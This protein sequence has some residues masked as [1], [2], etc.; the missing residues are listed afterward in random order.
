MTPHEFIA[1]WKPVDL[2][3]RSA[4]QQH[5]LDLCELLGQ[6]KPAAADPEGAW[7][8]F[9]KGVHKTEGGQGWADAWMKNHFGWEYKGKHRDL[10]AAYTQLQQYREALEN[11][12]LLVVCDLDRFEIHTNFTG[13]ITRVFAF[14]L[15]GLAQPANLDVLR[16]LFTD[17][18]AL[19]PGK[20]TEALTKEAAEH[21]GQVADGMWQRGIPAHDAAHFL[22]KLIFCMFAEDIGLLPNKVFTKALAAAKK[23]P[24]RL[25]KVLKD[26]FEAMAHG[27]YFGADE[28]L[29]FNGG[30]FADSAVIDLQAREIERLN[31]VC[32]FDWS[33]VEPSIFGTLFERTLDPAKRSQIGAHYTSRDDILT[34]LEPVMMAPLRREW[35]AIKA[36]CDALFVKLRE[37]GPKQSTRRKDSKPRRDFDQTIREFVER[38]A[39]VT[40]LDPACGSGNFLYVAINLLLDLEKEVIAY[41]S[42]RGVTQLPQVRPTQLAGIELNEYAQQLA[43]IVIW[44]GYLQWMHHNG[45]NP[46]N[47]PVLEPIESIRRM[48]AII[49]M[50]DSEHPIEPEWPSAEFIV[51]NPP[52][53]GSR[54]LR[55]NLGDDYVGK[56]FRVY[57]DRISKSADLCCYWFEKA[58]HQIET[59]RSSRAGLLATQSIR[60]G[61]SRRVLDRIRQS[62]DIYF[63]VSDRNWI[64]EGAMVHVSL[65]GFDDGSETTRTIDGQPVAEILSTLSSQAA[66]TTARPLR[67]NENVSFQ[68][69]TPMGPF[70]VPE[71]TALQFLRDVNPNRYPNSDVVRP[72]A[73][74]ADLIDGRQD[75]WVID[76]PASLLEPEASAYT[77][78]FEYARKN[79]GSA[80]GYLTLMTGFCVKPRPAALISLWGYG[81]IAG[82]WYIKPSE[83]Y[84]Q[85]PLVTKDEAWKGVSGPPVTSRARGDKGS[86]RFYLH[87]RQQGLW[88]TNVAGIDPRTQDPALT[89]Y[90]PARNVTRDYPPTILLHGTRDT[91]VPFEQSVEMDKELT[92]AGVEHKLIPIPN[93]GHGVGDGDPK[94]V[95]SAFA[96]ALQF[97]ERYVRHST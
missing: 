10:K 50:S 15:D 77:S 37:A 20:T 83:F 67:R 11:P 13:T 16:K 27:G 39:H 42:T 97:V 25:A 96:Q 75:R 41:A 9:E 45:F 64:L 35:D 21:I 81:D 33:D 5:F 8:T 94:L 53:L 55:I 85:Q 17:P 56:L 79:G 92:R 72:W 71:A 47:N 66:A 68:G 54:R 12:P 93:A 23:T 57:R 51:G 70:D 87:C 24:D 32:Q 43:Q 95:T 19:K 90:C 89:P 2:S 84:R 82:D 1:K 44:I 59:G 6:P 61:A 28:I 40:V 74:G 88:T 60:G 7:Y 69:V 73:N 31:V 80:G 62:G 14:D 3:E 58:R 29:Y 30:L 48:D 26:L 65:I 49:D 86:G 18:D 63:A 4:C 91:D 76:F 52:F 36:K 22:M 46:P 78:P 34:L 38:L